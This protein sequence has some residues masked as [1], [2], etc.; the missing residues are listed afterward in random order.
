MSL[1]VKQI[2]HVEKSLYQDV[3]VFQ[4][5][6]YGTV[7]V[8]D[9]VIQ[10]TE[11]DE[12][13][14]QE[15]IT[16]IALNSH[17]DPKKVL[18]IGG[19]DGGV[20]REVVKHESIQEVTLCEIDEA[21][22]RVSKQYLPGM[23]VGFDHSKVIVHI[24]DGFPFLEDKVN[25]FD[26][27][28]TDASDPVGPAESLFQAKYFELMRNALRPG[29]IISTQGECQWLHLPLIK[30]VQNHCKTL[31]PVVE[32][33]FTTIPTYP[34][35]QIGFMLCCKEEGRNLRKPIRRYTLEQ[36]AKLFR[37]YNADVHEAAFA[38]PQPI[39]ASHLT[40]LTNT[41]NIFANVEAEE[42]DIAVIKK[43]ATNF[44]SG[45]GFRPVLSR[46]K[47]KSVALEEGISEKGVLTKSSE[48]GDTTKSE[49]IDIE[50]TSFDYGESRTI[51]DGDHDQ[52]PKGPGVKT[53]KALGKPLGRIDF[54]DH[55]NIDDNIFLDVSLKLPPPLKNLVAVSI[56]KS[57]ALDIGLDKVVGKSFQKKLIMVRNLFSKVN[58]FGEASTPSKF[59][60]IIRAS[61]TSESS[62]AQ[63]TKKTRV[64]NILVNTNLK[65]SSN[66]SDW[67]VIVKKIPV[68]ISAETVHVV[69]TE[70]GF[71][72]SIKI[73]LFILIEKDAV[74][75]TKSNADKELWDI[76]NQHR[77]LL[78]ILLMGTNAHNIWDFIGFVSKKTCVINKH[79][80]TYAWARCAV[81][82]F[83]SAAL[84]NAVIETTPV[85]KS[86]NLHWSYMSSAKYAKCEN[87]GHISLNCFVDE[88]VSSDGTTHRMLLN[89]D[90]SR[91]ASIY[92]KHSAPISHLVSFGG[93]S[94]TNIVGG[95]SFTSLPVCN[96]L[97]ASGFSLEI[98]PIPMVSIELNNRFATLKRSLVS[99]TECVDKLAKRLNSPEPTPLVI[100]SSQNQEVD[101]VMSE[102]S[103][104][105][106]SSETIAEV[107]VFDFSVV[108]KI[109]KTLKNLSV[110]VMSLLAKIDNAGLSENMVFIV[111]ETKLRF[112]VRPWIMNKFD[113]VCIFTSGLI[114]GYLG[115]GVKEVPGCII[116]VHLLFKDKVLV[117]IIGLYACA[118][119]VVNSSNFVVLGGDFNEDKSMRSASFRFCLSID[120]VNSFSRHP[121]AGASMW[122][123]L[124]GIEKVI[125]HVFVSESL[126]SAVTSHGVE[127]VAGFFDTNHRAIS[128]SVNLGGLLDMYL[129]NIHRHTNIDYWKFKLKNCSLDKFLKKSAVFHDAERGNILK[130]ITINSAD[131]IFS[132]IWYCEFDSAKNKTFSKFHELELLMS[133][134]VNTMINEGARIVNI[135]Q[136]ISVVK[137]EY[138]RSKYHKLKIVR[139]ESIRA[140]VAKCMENFCSDKERIIKSILNQPFRKVVLNYL[141]YIV[142]DAFSEIMSNISLNKLLVVVK[143]FG[144][145]VF[146]DLLSVLNKCLK[147]GSVLTHTLTNTRPIMLILS[148]RIFLVCSRCNV[149]HSNNFSVLKG[150]FTQS[151]IFA[152]G[153]IV[154]DALEKNRELWLI[155]QDMHKA[156]DSVGWTHLCN[157]LVRIKMCSHFISFFGSIHNGRFNWVMMDFGLSD[158]YIVHDGLDQGEVFSPLL[159]QI[160]YDP[161]LCKVKKH[162]QLYGYKMCSN[163][164]TKSGRPDI[165]SGSTSF[166]AA[167]GTMHTLALCNT[168]LGG[169]LSNVFK[170]G[171]GVPILDVLGMKG[172][173]G[174]RKFLRKYGLIFPNQL[175][176][177]YGKCFTWNTFCR[178]KR[179]NSRGSIPTWFVFISNFIKCSGLSNNMVMAFHSASADVVYNTGFV[180]EWLLAAKCDFINV[181]TNS[182]VKDL[183]FI[184]AYGN[185]AAYFP[186]ANASIGVKV[187][188]LLFSMLVEL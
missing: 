180:S 183:G 53:K 154:E 182:S 170:A 174:V 80:V 109:E 94:W 47:R 179:L 22:I 135:V 46:K 81:V 153:S 101:I 45:E 11:R 115:A 107:A 23:A 175:L 66:H 4:S 114:D 31:F 37:Y 118:S 89:D 136:H 42:I 15:M 6:T 71:V 58:G 130:E 165:N 124:R 126:I 177:H 74:K 171:S 169:I 14:Y 38:L 176:D 43:T 164:Y 16:H 113:G 149:L 184:D 172:Y 41:R 116:L 27:I 122:D 93:V 108:S 67:A 144:S 98:K 3:L 110:T 48:T 166:F 134:I 103:G 147:S 32:Y 88:K 25:S 39:Y 78:Y 82:C 13:A 9:G 69:L 33:A 70:F 123:N 168:F 151:P 141:V 50:E 160:F 91:L 64:V 156:Y 163:F 185:A 128:V 65:K 157:S 97:A 99:L 133:K 119:P 44:G 120:L 181:Y 61:F 52:T 111:M 173:L 68:G 117:S 87:L 131:A 56:R 57:F 49:S 145:L 161:L 79:S 167:A 86:A 95:S 127:S 29:G 24:G 92:A 34:S 84:I 30:E 96:G 35:G 55:D 139:D 143:E 102:G 26:V 21:V 132:R 51:A 83:N 152:V 62:L 104:V 1:R 8:L 7:L 125:D 12:F 72:V 100:P 59:L 129:A 73:Q 178:W 121:L 140:A 138:H 106:T 77:V 90:K 20:L 188:G 10:C 17:P 137:K 155:L 162:K 40:S 142:D 112:N 148:D 105:V 85:L 28:I 60:G 2:L 19:G 158:G 18:V 75:V 159:W 54:L 187:F 186:K 36:E 63:A 150:T 146:N 76:K 5:E